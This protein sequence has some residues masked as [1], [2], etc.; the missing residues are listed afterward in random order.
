M[1]IL[2][3]NALYAIR[4]L[5]K[6]PG[7]TCLAVLTLALGIGLN[8]AVF[9]VVNAILFRPLPVTAPDELVN[10]YTEEDAGFIT[11]APMSFPDFEDFARETRSLEGL[12]A[13]TSS[14]LV[15]EHG[16]KSEVIMSETVSGNYFDLL[17]VP[18]VTG[19]TFTAEEDADGNA[20]FVAV[21]SHSA[22]QRRFGGDPGIVGR[23]LRL[24][25]Y[26]FTVVGVADP[27][28]TGMMR[29]FAPEVW[30][31][32]RTS[33]TIHAGSFSNSGAP[34]EGLDRLDDR[35]RRW[36]FVVARLADGATVE[37]AS[38][39]ITTLGMRL[40][41]EFPDSNDERSF[42]L[43]PTAEVR[44]F[45]GFDGIVFAGSMVVLGIV[46]LV[47]LIA[48]ANLANMLLARAVTRRKEI[49]TRLALGASRGAVVR[50]LLV[51]SLV[52]ALV[53]GGVGLLLAAGS[54][55]LVD[56][57]SLPLPV[58][59]HL[60]LALDGRVALFTLALATIAAV[61]FGLAPAFETTR[62]NLVSALSDE[63]RGSSAGRGKRRLRDALVVAQVALSLVLLICAGLAVR[64]MGNA[65]RIDP[66][67]DSQG[68]VVARVSP[69]T[70]GYSQA[71]AEDF[72][73]RLDERLSARSDIRA[74]GFAGHLPLTFNI[75]MLGAAAEGQDSVPSEEWP[76]FDTATVG[77][78]YLETMGIDVLQ[79]RSFTE[80]DD[81]D[82]PRVAVINET[83]AARLW[84][85]QDAIGKR[86]RIEEYEDYI[87]VVGVARDGKY[88]TLGEETRPFV[89]QA[90][91]QDW[92]GSQI[93]IART[94]GDPAQALATI[95]QQVRDLDANLAIGQLATIEDA[96][97]SAL[98]LP[99]L[100][101]ALFGLFGIIGLVLAMTGIYGV[102]SYLVSQRTHEIGIRMAMGAHGGDI[103]RLVV[104][105]GL[106]LTAV[107]V[108]LGVIAALA[109]TRVL[110][111]ILYGISATDAMTFVLVPLTLTLVALLAT[112][113]PSWRASRLDPLVALHHE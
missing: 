32:I 55:F 105:Q 25:G 76:I 111:G 71:Q 8:S 45:P 109:M 77:P 58:D 43:L 73:R 83:A 48:C 85:G 54:N 102:V 74:T 13:Y 5:T 103:L 18:A 4:K 110:S 52:L 96:T 1:N 33:S 57:V 3:R 24:N 66:G 108:V 97:A 95:R 20:Q 65:H 70:Q 107:G 40:S 75:S 78:D 44:F 87:E 93:L 49:A 53:G 60:G 21:I 79:G 72:F 11:H 99:R 61:A 15:L 112:A 68:L 94:T 19:R 84:P 38:A 16:E 51:E 41:Q 80:W 22:W 98:V 67:F 91:A 81:E 113:I 6:C 34:T 63:T 50:Q 86:L 64:S 28:F 59:L 101:A 23:D 10:I 90:I 14:G 39:E 29:G 27:S 89:Y 88:R 17:G 106:R 46:T 100:G 7:F 30:I 92:K 56:R 9:S 2:L 31:P 37:Q 47:L 42:A 82:A 35:G 36:H 104:R 26:P 69:E 62:A 12:A